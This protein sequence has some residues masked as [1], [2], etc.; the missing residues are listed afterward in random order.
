MYNRLINKL[1]IGTC[2]VTCDIFDMT[3]LIRPTLV[4][5]PLS[6]RLAFARPRGPNTT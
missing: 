5:S 6:T 1:Y 4:L 3:C 2:R